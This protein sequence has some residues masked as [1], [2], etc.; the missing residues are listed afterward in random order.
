VQASRVRWLA[1]LVDRDTTRFLD[2]FPTIL[3]AFQSRAMQY[4]CLVAQRR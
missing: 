1:R 4:G 2:H 3:R